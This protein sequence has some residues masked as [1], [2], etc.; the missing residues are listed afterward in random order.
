MTTPPGLQPERTALAWRRT[1]LAATVVFVLLIRSAVV[2]PS[3]TTLAG[4]G[5]ALVVL[6]SLAATARLRRHRYLRD[7]ADPRPIPVSAAAAVCAGICLTACG[8]LP[9][10]A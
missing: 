10:P 6:G 7:P 2:S 4:L 3:P 5:A 8:A 9:P 1:L